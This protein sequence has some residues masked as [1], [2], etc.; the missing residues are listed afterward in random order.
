MSREEVLLS[1]MAA[2]VEQFRRSC[3]QTAQELQEM[4]QRVPGT[5]RQ[6]TDEQIRRLPGEVMGSVRGGIEQPVA[7]YEQRLRHAGEQLQHASYALTTQL[8]RAEALHKQLIWKVAGITLGSLILLLVGG[9]WLSKHYYD[10]IRQNR[11][12]AELL[13]AYNQAD[14]TVCGDRLCAKVDRKDKR[15]GDYVP[16]KPR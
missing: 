6:A 15:Y 13:K 9:G 5:V 12:S 2:L 4:V 11:I 1:Q 10:E 3:E 16:I 8:Q 14:V 7:A